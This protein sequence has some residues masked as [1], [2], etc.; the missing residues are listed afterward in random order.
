MNYWL[1]KSDPEEY[2]WKELLH[3]QSA[4]WTG[5][6]NFTARNNLKAMKSGDHVLFYHSQTDKGVVGIAKVVKEFHPDPTA[7]KGEPW[8]AVDLAPVKALDKP[9][10]LEQVKAEKRLS[11]IHLVRQGRLSVMP[12]KKEEFDLMVKMGE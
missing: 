5:V 4:V 11:E 10:T 9:V 1:V 12:L 2:G 6:R 7:A 3:D 8:V